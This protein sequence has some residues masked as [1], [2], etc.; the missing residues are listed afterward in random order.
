MQFEAESEKALDW[1]K[2]VSAKM[3]HGE[4]SSD[5]SSPSSVGSD[6]LKRLQEEDQE[7]QKIGQVN[8]K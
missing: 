2:D 1:I 3:G 4:I 8:F 5:Q 6:I 7:R